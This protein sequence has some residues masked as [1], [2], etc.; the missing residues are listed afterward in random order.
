[1]KPRENPLITPDLSLKRQALIGRG[2]P[3]VLSQSKGNTRRDALKPEESEI[4]SRIEGM[5]VKIIEKNI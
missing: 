4:Q 5:K 3:S 1:M 2:A